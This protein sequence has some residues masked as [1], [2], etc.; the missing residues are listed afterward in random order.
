MTN[1]DILPDILNLAVL[2]CAVIL[3][4]SIGAG[5]IFEHMA[6]CIAVSVVPPDDNRL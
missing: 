5:G 4:S 2:F 3:I 6:A 1:Y